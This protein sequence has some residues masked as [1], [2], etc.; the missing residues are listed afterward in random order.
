MPDN[1]ET[2]ESW[3]DT[4]PDEIK[5][6]LPQDVIKDPNITKYRTVDEFM[7]GHVNLVQ[8]IGQ[9]GVILPNEKS[10]PEERESFFNQIGRPSKP[11]EYKFTKM[12]N[13]HKS[14]QV[15]PESEKVFAGISHK[16]GL[17]NEQADGLNKWYM[18]VIDGTLK[19]QDQVFEAAKTKAETD[20]RAEWKDGYDL[21][22]SLAKSVVEK[23]GGPEAVNAIGDLGNNPA[24]LKLFA[25]I[26]ESMSE[27]TF[28]N[29]GTTPKPKDAQT[30][31]DAIKGDMKHAY[32]NEN[33]PKHFEAV[34]HVKK[35]Y[36]TIGA[37]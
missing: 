37:Q 3:V 5:T 36:E 28:K 29:P 6:T 17:T 7:K 14:I 32:W 15:T 30:E 26:G 34:Q 24:A 35:L 8:K 18:G 11:E 12:E 19:Q 23:F 27:D 4:L 22:K 13:I 10:T 33:D 1:T 25:K 2:V 9:K 21:K 16:L 20:L 31:L